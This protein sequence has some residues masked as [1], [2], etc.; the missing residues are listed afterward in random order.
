MAEKAD[1]EKLNNRID[2]LEELIKKQQAEMFKVNY[3]ISNM[4]QPSYGPIPIQ[5]YNR[6]IAYISPLKFPA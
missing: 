5:D 1:I 2:F 4:K 3:T 6:G